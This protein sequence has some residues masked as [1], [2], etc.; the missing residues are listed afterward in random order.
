MNA[1]DSVCDELWA[2]WPDLQEKGLSTQNVLVYKIV[3]AVGN[4][5]LDL[6]SAIA[7]RI[8]LQK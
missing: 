5:F 7:V 1:P 3:P 8:V 4:L 2:S 6:A